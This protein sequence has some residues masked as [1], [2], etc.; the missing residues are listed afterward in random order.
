MDD[1]KSAGKQ[2]L[3]LLLG[4]LLCG[5]GL[6]LFAKHVQ[7]SSYGDGFGS[8]YGRFG[9]FGGNG[10]PGGLVVVPLILGIMIWV[11]FPQNFAGK[12]ITILGTLFIIVGVLSSIKLTNPV[13]AGCGYKE[14]KNNEDRW[15]E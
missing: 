15:V 9:A 11:I 14:E 2:L 3:L 6:Y 8:M 10:I 1:S 7:V 5:A 13:Y 12:F 4:M